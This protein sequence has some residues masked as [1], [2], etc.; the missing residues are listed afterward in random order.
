MAVCAHLQSAVLISPH[1]HVHFRKQCASPVLDILLRPSRQRSAEEQTPCLLLLI[2]YLFYTQGLNETSPPSAQ[3][4]ALSPTL[5]RANPS[6]ATMPSLHIITLPLLITF[7][8]P[9]AFL[10]FLTTTFAASVLLLRLVLV[11][12]ELA[13]YLLPHY[14][15]L[16]LHLPVLTSLTVVKSVAPSRRNSNTPSSS[17]P[18]TRRSRR[19]SSTSLSS[20]TPALRGSASAISLPLPQS[21]PLRDF[22][23]VGGWR[24]SS[25]DSDDEGD[26]PWTRINSRLV[27]PAESPARH[28]RR[29][30][31]GGNR[32]FFLTNESSYAVDT[33]GSSGT[34]SPNTKRMRTPTHGFTAANP[35]GG[36]GYFMN[37]SGQSVHSVASSAAQGGT[38]GTIASLSGSSVSSK[39][40]GLSGGLTMKERNG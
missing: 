38:M 24:L 40:S 26:D 35:V 21:N 11:Y 31:T 3:H 10:A 32:P 4:H 1:Y 15:L 9:L 27:L 14:I 20:Q 36:E 17:P 18:R 25:N 12:I 19:L 5:N 6:T 8:L 2:L 30:W 34:W 29:S 22:E 37:V 28:H 33:G 7:S 23:G 13:I 39:S 16:A